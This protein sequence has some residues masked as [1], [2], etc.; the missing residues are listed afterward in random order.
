MR[1]HQSAADAHELLLQPDAPRPQRAGLIH[2]GERGGRRREVPPRARAL[3]LRRHQL[4]QPNGGPEAG[5]H[6]QTYVRPSVLDKEFGEPLGLCSERGPGIFE[7]EWSLA[8]VQHDCNMGESRL[9][10]KG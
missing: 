8:T 5:R 10:M 9:A 7:R 2:S 3:R 4:G 6:N 1:A